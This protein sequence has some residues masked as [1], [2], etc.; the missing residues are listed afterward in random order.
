VSTAA[1]TAVIVP[2]PAA[3]PYVEKP[4]PGI[5]PHITLL[6]PYV[7]P[8]TDGVVAELREVLAGVARFDVVFARVE[9]F[10][11]VAYLAP[12]PADPFAELTAELVRR[13]PECPPYGGAFP[14]VPHL[15][16]AQGEDAAL[17]RVAAD[18]APRLPLVTEAVEAQLLEEG[19]PWRLAAHFPFAGTQAGM[20]TAVV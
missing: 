18:V 14:V 15:T 19:D 10:P 13:H 12:E 6:F 11:G 9:R 5:P 4:T 16:I 2:F 20:R 7:A 3:A 1:R 8:V 17:D